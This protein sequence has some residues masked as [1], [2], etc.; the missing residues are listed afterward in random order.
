VATLVDTRAVVYMARGQFDAAVRDMQFVIDGEPRPN[1]FF[2]LA[3]AYD[4]AN[5]PAAATKA[6]KK[7]VELG[8][9]SDQLH[10]LE[11]SGFVELAKKLQ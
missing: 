3:R 1:R 5:Q 11:R 6:L 7:A 2:H 4:G 8:L 9:T 10:P